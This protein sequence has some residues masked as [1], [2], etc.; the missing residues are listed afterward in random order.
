MIF[1]KEVKIMAV[2]FQQKREKT[3]AKVVEIHCEQIAEIQEKR[4][5]P[6]KK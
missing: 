5:I 2:I 6:L 4:L 1:T 3:V